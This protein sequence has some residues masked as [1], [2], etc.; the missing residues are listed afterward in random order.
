MEF[1]QAFSDF[2]D[3]QCHEDTESLLFTIIRSAFASGWNR[4]KQQSLSVQNT[5]K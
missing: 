3:E 1:E 5:P 4:A 2:I